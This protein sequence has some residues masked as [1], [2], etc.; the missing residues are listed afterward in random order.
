VPA[1]ADAVFELPYPFCAASAAYFAE[2]GMYILRALG[3][4]TVAFGS[5]SGDADSLAVL[6]RSVRLPARG[7][8]EGAAA[9]MFG[10]GDRRP[11][12]NDI[13][14]ANY[15][16][17]AARL[18]WEPCFLPVLRIGAGKGLDDPDY[19]SSAAIRRSV[20]AG[21]EPA[22][23]TGPSLRVMA[24][25][26][27]AGMYPVAP[28]AAEMMTVA[29]L[30]TTPAEELSRFAECGGGVAGR[31]RGAAMR[32]DGTAPLSSLAA[33]K[34]YTDARLRRAALFALTG[35]T[36]G[37]LSAR[38]A[39][40][41]LLAAS[42]RGRSYL[43]SLTAGPALPVVTRNDGI[44]DGPGAARQYELAIAMDSLYTLLLPSPL[45]AD[46]LQKLPPRMEG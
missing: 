23:V 20:L 28:D 36:P 44:P 16:A 12:P 4:D 38:P 32:Y 45:A 46:R 43:R 7:G 26:E 1:G 19:P 39:Y 31:L 35:V 42:A 25:A 27:R 3:A 8:A 13:L 11:G 2:A 14:A 33:T 6:S 29:F 40:V 10:G 37:D 15:I 30:R 9:A 22:G 34:K 18:G 5:E 41:R 21:Q 24:E 17:A